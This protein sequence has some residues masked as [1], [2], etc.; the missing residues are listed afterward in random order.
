MHGSTFRST[1]E[2][3]TIREPDKEKTYEN[4]FRMRGAS[5]QAENGSMV[6]NEEGRVS[7]GPVTENSTSAWLREQIQ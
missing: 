6:C 3:L 4:N 5:V 2:D 1:L 7:A